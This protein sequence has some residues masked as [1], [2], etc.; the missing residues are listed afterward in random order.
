MS[1]SGPFQPTFKIPLTDKIKIQFKRKLDS[2]FTYQ[3]FARNKGFESH[4][5]NQNEKLFQLK[6]EFFKIFISILLFFGQILN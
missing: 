1:I 3:R 5:K 4:P 6:R 2:K